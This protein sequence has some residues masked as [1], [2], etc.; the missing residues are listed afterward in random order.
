[1]SLQVEGLRRFVGRPAERDRTFT[2]VVVTA[3]GKG[4]VGTSSVTALI[5]LGLARAGRRVLIVD[6][7]DGSLHLL[8]GLDAGAGLV[9]FGRRPADEGQLE[10]VD[11]GLAVLTSGP[12]VST[13]L[14]AVR[15]MERRSA[16]ARI[17]SLHTTFDLV[18]IDGGSSV[19]SVVQAC[20]LGVDRLLT[21]TDAGRLAM[22]GT[23]GLLRAVSARFQG[24]P[25]QLVVN[26]E[27]PDALTRVDSRVR[28]ALQHFHSGPVNTAGLIPF[29][30]DL[31]E[32]NRQD[33]LLQ[34]LPTS[35]LAAR[36]ALRLGLTMTLG[37][38]L[39]TAEEPVNRALEPTGT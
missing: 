2:N 12:N 13:S 30:P 24:L 32:A 3:G 9:D 7:S 28:S 20:S 27:R 36:A 23:F 39:E 11:S 21:V 35:S 6:G 14:S 22:A 33:G 15:T 25:L 18:M 5:G 17:A 38:R 29:D 10:W 34:E 26:R 37:T 4:G 19:D 8:L 31:E 16:L 1:M